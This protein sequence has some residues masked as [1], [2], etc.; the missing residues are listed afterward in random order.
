VPS[1]SE[2]ADAGVRTNESPI[3]ADRQLIHDFASL[4]KEGRTLLIV[5]HREELISA[6]AGRVWLLEGGG[7]SPMK[8]NCV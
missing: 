1:W 7:L 3:L 4:Q 2:N 5:E 8:G 6:V